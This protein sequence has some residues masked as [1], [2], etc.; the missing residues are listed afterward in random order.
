MDDV[1][2]MGED[3]FDT[4]M[5]PE[6]LGGVGGIVAG[7][8]VSGLLASTLSFSSTIGQVVSSGGIVLIGAGIY[9]YGL[10]GRVMNPALR[11]AAQ[12]TGIVVGGVGHG[13]LLPSFG[14]PSFGLGAEGVTTD[15]MGLPDPDDGRVIGQDYNGRSVGQAAEDE[16]L[17]L[18]NTDYQENWNSLQNNNAEE[19]RNETVGAPQVDEADPLAYQAKIT[20]P[21]NPTWTSGVVPVKNPWAVP[22]ELGMVAPSH[23]NVSEWFGSAEGVSFSPRRATVGAGN[24]HGLNGRGSVIG[25]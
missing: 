19:F 21:A 1:Y 3:A 5:S 12:V 13:K 4:S 6:F 16:D 24:L 2:E 7:A 20:Q 10:S 9:G 8:M 17:D 15:R 14:A 11:S 23:H 25:Q 22:E 18:A